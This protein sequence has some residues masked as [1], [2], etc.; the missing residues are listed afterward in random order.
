M[1]YIVTETQ[2]KF[3]QEIG[4]LSGH[5][6]NEPL[7]DLF[8]YFAKK[9][10][11]KFKHKYFWDYFNKMGFD[12][13]YDEFFKEDVE[14]YFDYSE[15]SEWNDEFKSKDSRSG[16]AYYIAK[17]H[18][19]LKKGMEIDY[20]IRKD[21]DYLIYYFFDSGLKIFVGKM[22]IVERDFPKGAFKV[23]LSSADEELIGTGYGTKMYLTILHDVKYLLSDDTL[24]SGSYRMWK[25]VLPRYVNVWGIQ[26]DEYSEKNNKF[27][28]IDPE[29]KMSVRK[30]DRF[31]ASSKY[32]KIKL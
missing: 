25:H 15:N 9:L 27:T 32:D 30:F 2:Y 31:I 19:G 16:L 22:S 26:E 5:Y 4:R 13:E 11:N 23:A 28:K 8:E 3:I 1:K 29:K 17:K 10:P 7:N 21:E 24:F 18:F 6:I 12:L 14:D 20:F